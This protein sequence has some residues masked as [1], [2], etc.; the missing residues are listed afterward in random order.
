MCRHEE[1]VHSETQTSLAVQPEENRGAYLGIGTP[2]DHSLAADVYT[3]H[4]AAVLFKGSSALSCPRH[5][6]RTAQNN[7]IPIGRAFATKA[8]VY[9]FS[10]VKMKNKKSCTTIDPKEQAISRLSGVFC[11]CVC[12]EAGLRSCHF[13]SRHV[14]SSIM[15]CHVMSRYVTSCP[16][17]SARAMFGSSSGILSRPF[18]SCHVTSSCHKQSPMSRREPA[19][20]AEGV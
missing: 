13:M 15:S 7:G 20:H 17:I 6:N 2:G 4:L 11:G 16:V 5:S 3:P 18:F 8:C 19:A 9:S 12:N 10:A 1:Q 14:V